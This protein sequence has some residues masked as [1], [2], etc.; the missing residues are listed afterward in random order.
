MEGGEAKVGA[1]AV[2]A[3]QLVGLAD[4]PL[5]SLG[6]PS[7]ASRSVNTAVAVARVSMIGCSAAAVVAAGS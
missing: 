5:I 2:A 1:E 6:I 3:D 4:G 7:K